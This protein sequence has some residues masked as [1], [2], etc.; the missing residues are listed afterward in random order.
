[1]AELEVG[2]ALSAGWRLPLKPIGRIGWVGGRVNDATSEALEWELG[3]WENVFELK[4]A[5]LDTAVTDNGRIG[6]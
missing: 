2:I 4:S 1:V 6:T 5:P 3:N